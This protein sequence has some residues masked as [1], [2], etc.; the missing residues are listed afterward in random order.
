M[1]YNG[2]I[3]SLRTWQPRVHQNVTLWVQNIIKAA[4]QPWVVGV[5]R[6]YVVSAL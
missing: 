2:H 1:D 6:Y 5:R 4:V 3:H